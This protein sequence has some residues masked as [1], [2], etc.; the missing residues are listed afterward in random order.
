M[1]L[2]KND[3]NIVVVYERVKNDINGN[4]RYRIVIFKDNELVY[5]RKRQVNGDLKATIEYIIKSEIK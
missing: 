4:A 3:N 5:D 2:Y 1:E